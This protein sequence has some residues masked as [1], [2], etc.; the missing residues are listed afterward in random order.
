[1]D[2]YTNYH[3][4]VCKLTKFFYVYFCL[5]GTLIKKYI[6]PDTTL[7]CLFVA[8]CMSLMNLYFNKLLD[9]EVSSVSWSRKSQTI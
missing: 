8:I 4:E 6:E 3:T 2:T 7:L 5:H 1:M 9:G